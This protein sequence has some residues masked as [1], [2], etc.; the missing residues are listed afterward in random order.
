MDNEGYLRYMGELQICRRDLQEDIRV[1]VIGMV[2]EEE[3]FL[4]DYIKD[5]SKFRFKII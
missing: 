2:I 4:L 3:L 1:N 5:E